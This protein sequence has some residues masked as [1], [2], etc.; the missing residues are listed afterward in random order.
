MKLMKRANRSEQRPLRR[1]LWQDSLL[2]L[3]L[4]AVYF[5]AFLG[6]R[7][8]SIP[9]EGRY[10]E[11]ARE[12]F[13]SGN[14]VTPTINGVPF[15]DKPILYY[16]LECL[17]Y[18]VFG[19]NNW[20][21]R[22]PGALFGIGGVI[23]IYWFG[24]YF[25][26]R[27]SGLFA[28]G[29]LAVSPL[30]FLA[31][32][33]ANIDLE[34]GNLLWLSALLLLWG[35]TL[36]WPSTRRRLVCYGAYAAGGLAFLAKGMIGI[37]FPASTLLLWIALLNR[38]RVLRQVYLF[39]GL[40]IFAGVIAPWLVLV[41]GE[42]PDFLYYFFYYQQIG[43]FLGNDFHVSH[44]MGPY[45]FF[46][47]L[48]VGMV[49]WS[50]I[51]SARIYKGLKCLWPQRQSHPLSLFLLL[52]CLFILLFFSIPDTKLVGYILP[53]MGPGALL[54][55]KALDTVAAKGL[56]RGFVR[57]YG[58]ASGVLVLT[59]LALLV[60]PV[61][62]E[63]YAAGALYPV[64]IP[65]ALVLLGGAPPGYYLLRR[66]QVGRSFICMVTTMI[67]FN[68]GVVL[69]APVFDTRGSGSMIR[70]LKQYLQPNSIVICYHAYREDIPLMLQRK[71]YLVGDWQNRR[72]LQTDNWQREFFFGIHEYE[73]AN[74][75]RWP[76]Y[77]I[78]DNQFALLWER[79]PSVFVFASQSDYRKLAGQLT[80]PPQLIARH[81][82][83]VVLGKPPLI[84]HRENTE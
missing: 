16:W 22:M 5:I 33:Y 23:I 48:L 56:T 2:L 58:L 72:L 32:H 7:A 35:L 61:A 29:I 8:L 80:P 55:G 67:V 60:F 11:I 70:P 79:Y 64:F 36:P 63:K 66:N 50:I 46:M 81:H 41:Q 18:A 73:Q 78:F 83:M 26:N 27:R 3:A 45:F 84:K 9:D 51:F 53:V 59:G 1:Q 12:M 34:V 43:R 38:W 82:G 75:G 76:R 69:S 31:A 4:A 49:P 24:R 68:L 6:S 28:A 37:V 62:Q 10:P 25:Y 52:W 13:A 14:W 15:L 39:S 74:Q 42:N 47:V 17:S 44:V 20:A 77:F 30:Y 54:M 40:L 65:M 57:A 71:V 19:V 21:I